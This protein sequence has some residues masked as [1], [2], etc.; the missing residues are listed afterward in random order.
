M[1]R[2]MGDANTPEIFSPARR[3]ASLLVCSRPSSESCTS[4]APANRS[5]AVKTVAP[6]RTMKIRV[7]EAAMRA[8]SC[9]KSGCKA[10]FNLACGRM[11]VSASVRHPPL[12]AHARASVRLR[13]NAITP[14][15]SHCWLRVSPIPP[16]E[17]FDWLMPRVRPLS[18]PSHRPNSISLLKKNSIS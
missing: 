12:N 18:A 4:V 9:P 2:P 11:C 7:A 16:P 1:V 10:I 17:F 5:S 8:I 3:S 15:R 13:R 6:C 14:T